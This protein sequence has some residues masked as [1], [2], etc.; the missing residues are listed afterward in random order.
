MPLVQLQSK[1][2]DKMG[3][4]HG[5]RIT[6]QRKHTNNQADPDE[7]CNILGMQKFPRGGDVSNKENKNKPVNRLNALIIRGRNYYDDMM[8]STKH[9]RIVAGSTGLLGG[10]LS[11]VA[12][13]KVGRG[14]AIILGSGVFVLLVAAQSGY[15]EVNWNKVQHDAD[16]ALKLVKAAEKQ[17][18]EN[19]TYLQKAIYT[20]K[21]EAGRNAIVTTAFVAGVLIAVW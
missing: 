14:T 9:R 18:S 4:I 13:K 12:V 3:R 8:L 16:K 15:I 17:V 2:S 5:Y 11:G 20:V 19:R 21:K 10:W 7:Y 6:H 1:A